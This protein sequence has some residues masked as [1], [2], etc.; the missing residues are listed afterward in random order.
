MLQAG[1]SLRQD[2]P[3]SSARK[4]LQ[5]VPGGSA[6]GGTSNGTGGI[7]TGTTYFPTSI[8]WGLNPNGTEPHLETICKTPVDTVIV[9]FVTSYGASRPIKVSLVGH[10]GAQ[11]AADIRTCKAQGIKVLLSL[12][13]PVPTGHGEPCPYGFS[14]DSP[15]DY[16]DGKNASA[17]VAQQRRDVTE[18]ANTIYDCFFT[19]GTNCSLPA[20]ANPF[21]L[22]TT[23]NGYDLSP[24]CVSNAGDPAAYSLFAQVLAQRAGAG[25]AAGG[26]YTGSLRSTATVS[27]DYPDAILGPLPA[28]SGTQGLLGNPASAQFFSRVNLKYFG[29]DICDYASGNITTCYTPWANWAKIPLPAGTT[30]PVASAFD[31]AA[32]VKPKISVLIPASPTAPGATIWDFIP[33]GQLKNVLTPVSTLVN[34]V[35]AGVTLWNAASDNTNEDY[36]AAIRAALQPTVGSATGASTSATGA[37][38]NQPAR[39]G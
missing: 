28:S 39:S 16:I 26:R 24:N 33:T 20:S 1:S 4:L 11:T 17:A 23:F 15:A 34:G 5:F 18:V 6:G 31:R 30:S 12:G 27:A 10:D 19:N 8:F 38:A 36:A 25:E 29:T 14:S 13:G 3:N 22:N 37:V 7:G 32:P 21:G 35:F 2:P 9:G